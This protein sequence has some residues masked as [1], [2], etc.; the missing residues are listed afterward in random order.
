MGRLLLMFG[1]GG[2]GGRPVG[3]VWGWLDILKNNYMFAML[4]LHLVSGNFTLDKK[5]YRDKIPTSWLQ[6]CHL[7]CDGLYSEPSG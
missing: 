7:V 4:T 5:P 6:G 2:G 3:C 1:L